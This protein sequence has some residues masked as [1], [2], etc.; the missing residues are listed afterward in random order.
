V[1]APRVE[2]LSRFR[3]LIVE[4]SPSDAMLLRAE[5]EEGPLA[6]AALDQ[7]GTLDAALDRLAADRY[8]AVL[9]DLGLPDSDGFATFDAIV[10]AAGDAAVVVLTGRDDEQLADEAVEH[11]AQDYVVKGQRRPGDLARAVRYS[12]RRQQLLTELRVARDEQLAQKDNF[13]SH[14]SH[15]LRCPLAVVHQ[16]ASLLADGIAGELNAEQLDLLTVLIR[17]AEQLKAM[18]DDLL[19]VN[20]AGRDTVAIEADTIQPAPLLAETAAAFGP[21][22]ADRGVRLDHDVRP[23]P[24]VVADPKRVREILTNLVDNAL[25]FT[26]RGGRVTVA[27]AQEDGFVRFEVRDTGRGIDAAALPHVFDRFYQADQSDSTSRNGLGLGLYLCRDLVRRQGGELLAESSLGAGTTMS[28]TLPLAP[29]AA[30][31]AGT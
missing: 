7:A 25:K 9:T 21:A 20:R 26:P 30:T 16:F 27:A 23:L 8:D 4:D 11:G 31:R 12:V 17:N 15:E 14:V 22:A 29:A 5:L 19:L 6:G 1:Q 13:L 28:F 18:I 10:A 3:L 24:A 2:D